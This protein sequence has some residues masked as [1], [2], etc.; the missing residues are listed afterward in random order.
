MQ[1]FQRMKSGMIRETDPRSAKEPGRFNI[2][3]I[4]PHIVD[5]LRFG[6][7]LLAFITFF[8]Q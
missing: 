8:H 4:K 3:G 2:V 6:L 5:Q 1:V 7:Q